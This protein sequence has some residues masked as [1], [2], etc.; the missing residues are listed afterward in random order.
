[1]RSQRIP[2]EKLKIKRCR[3]SH[4][5]DTFLQG[6]SDA[7]VYL[8]F[9]GA[10]TSWSLCKIVQDFRHNSE[11]WWSTQIRSLSHRCRYLR[12]QIEVFCWWIW[13]DR[14][15]D[16]FHLKPSQQYALLFARCYFVHSFHQSDSVRVT[17]GRMKID[18]DCSSNPISD[19][20]FNALRCQ[21]ILR[22]DWVQSFPSF[23]SPI[24]EFSFAWLSVSWAIVI[25][26]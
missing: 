11:S 6:G 2:R 13:K 12:W 3:W 14:L 5:I 9:L 20:D 19:S 10:M 18:W 24:S 26:R 15:G 25:H 8:Y 23:S 7:D 1:M 17:I 16:R 21:Q 4:W 22:I